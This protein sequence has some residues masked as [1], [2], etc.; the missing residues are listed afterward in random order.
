MCAHVLGQFGTWRCQKFNCRDST[1]K[2]CF[3]LVQAGFYHNVK[4]V[5]GKRHQLCR[6]CV[7]PLCSN[8]IGS[9]LVSREILSTVQNTTIGFLPLEPGLLF[10]LFFFFLHTYFRLPKKCSPSDFF[11]PEWILKSALWSEA[12]VWSANTWGGVGRV[13]KYRLGQNMFKENLGSYPPLSTP[14]PPSPFHSSCSIWALSSLVLT[15]WQANNK[16]THCS[17]PTCIKKK[18]RAS[19]TR[20]HCLHEYVN[21]AFCRTPLVP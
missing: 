18:K 6:T 7:V 3:K 10:K 9:S 13:F 21:S 5:R 16:N 11:P 2:K 14:P 15:V 17:R 1:S 8:R 4:N 19:D 20:I 12:S